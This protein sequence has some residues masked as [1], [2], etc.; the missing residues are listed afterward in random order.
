MKS[1]NIKYSFSEELI[2]DKEFIKEFI[3][4]VDYQVYYLRLK[5]HFGENSFF[6]SDKRVLDKGFIKAISSKSNYK[7]NSKFK[8]QS[9]DPLFY[10]AYSGCLLNDDEIE[11]FQT[12]VYDIYD[13]FGRKGL[14]DARNIY[15]A[16]GLMDDFNILITIDDKE[17]IYDLEID[18]FFDGKKI[19]IINNLEYDPKQRIFDVLKTKVF[20]NYKNENAKSALFGFPQLLYNENKELI[21]EYEIKELLDR[22][23]ES[24]PEETM[25]LDYDL[26]YFAVEECKNIYLEKFSEKIPRKKKNKEYTK[27]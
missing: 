20:V 13:K 14:N 18:D 16:Q 3:N 7:W 25:E 5:E 23:T 22:I 21:S 4:N 27:K 11:K 8:E 2:E 26:Y 9:F 6:L 19:F 10:P 17:D 12:I 15:L 1:I 24:L